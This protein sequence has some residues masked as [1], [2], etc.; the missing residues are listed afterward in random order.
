MY[1]RYCHGLRAMIDMYGIKVDFC[2]ATGGI[3]ET[4][5]RKIKK[6]FAPEAAAEWARFIWYVYSKKKKATAAKSFS[7]QVYFMVLR[8]RLYV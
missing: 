4:T 5:E 3:K 1:G 2:I 8:T 6:V 7:C